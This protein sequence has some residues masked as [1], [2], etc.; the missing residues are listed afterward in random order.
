M[1]QALH[2]AIPVPSGVSH[3]RFIRT[4]SGMTIHM[5]P[6]VKTGNVKVEPG[7]ARQFSAPLCRLVYPPAQC[8][9]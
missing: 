4:D 3:G 7:S 1:Q 9:H 2:R 6:V 5:S 8:S